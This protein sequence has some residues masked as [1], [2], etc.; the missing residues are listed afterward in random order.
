[1]YSRG[2]HRNILGELFNKRTGIAYTKNYNNFEEKIEK[3]PTNDK[4]K[5]FA[6]IYE[7]TYFKNLFQE[8][9]QMIRLEPSK[10]DKISKICEN[11]V[12]N[13]RLLL[14]K[15]RKKIL[16][17]Y[18]EILSYVIEEIFDYESGIIT[19]G[20]EKEFIDKIKLFPKSNLEEIQKFVIEESAYFDSLFSDL[21]IALGV[22]SILPSLVKRNALCD[23]LEKSIKD[24]K[25]LL[26]LQVL[27][28]R[29]L[30]NEIF[31]DENGIAASTNLQ[32]FQNKVTNF[33]NKIS[34][35]LKEIV[36]ENKDF[37]EKVFED[38]R[39]ILGIEEIS[40]MP[41]Q[42][43][44]NMQ[45]NEKIRCFDSIIQTMKDFK[46]EFNDID[47]ID[48]LCQ[49]G[50]RFCHSPTMG[51]NKILASIFKDLAEMRDE[52][53]SQFKL[54]MPMDDV[55]FLKLCIGLSD[56]D[57]KVLKNMLEPYVKMPGLTA[58]QTYFKESLIPKSRPFIL[59]DKIVLLEVAQLQYLS[60]DLEVLHSSNLLGA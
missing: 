55:I 48:V 24:L 36:D 22:E 59:D 39:N 50:S 1:M 44:N 20:S 41:K 3:F 28:L 49:I 27:N 17:N 12:P 33:P 57:Q 8:I 35:I 60:L 29:P 14:T 13:L 51:N 11:C 56:N 7:K 58:I 4:L 10:E 43:F 21:K 32:E 23:L 37:F 46:N 40:I 30:W 19:F 31:D 42:S 16:P 26:N 54:R 45:R 47:E 5:I 2:L 9:R 38:L 18:G 52:F 6:T 53:Y 25:N 34:P 15:N